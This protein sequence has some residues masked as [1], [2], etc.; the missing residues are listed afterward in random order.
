[1]ITTSWSIICTWSMCQWFFQFLLCARISTTITRRSYSCCCIVM[2]LLI[3]NCVEL[4]I[5][6]LINVF[7]VWNNSS[8]LLKLVV[9]N[10]KLLNLKLIELI[11][12]FIQRFTT[13]SLRI[14]HARN[15][16]ISVL[17]D[18]GSTLNYGAIWAHCL[19]F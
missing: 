10:A 9:R 13:N 17:L 3:L 8:I 6:L 5:N 2:V 19:W 16:G 11:F 7:L 4:L 1:M 14:W 15:H 12:I 18:H